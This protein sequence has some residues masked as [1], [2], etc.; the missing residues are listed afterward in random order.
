[1]SMSAEQPCLE[2]VDANVLLYAYDLSAG[3]RHERAA[4]LVGALGAGRRGALSVQVL[5]E[6][7]VNATRK[8]AAPLGPDAA[9][10]RVRVLSRWTVHAPQAADVV[11]AAQLARTSQL[12]FWNAMIIRS[13]AALGCTTMWSEN[14]NDDQEIAGVLVRNPFQP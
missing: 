2:F 4:R 7:Y 12:S 3:D 11:G 8:I 13:A 10:D 5:Q 14:L 6:F 1:M 9:M